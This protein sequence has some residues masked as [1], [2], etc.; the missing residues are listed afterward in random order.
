MARL[1]HFDLQASAQ[2][3]LEAVI[4]GQELG[5]SLQHLATAGCST[6][7]GFIRSADNE[8]YATPSLSLVE[9]HRQFRAGSVPSDWG[10][11]S[12]CASAGTSFCA[13]LSPSQMS[14]LRNAFYHDFMRPNGMAY[15]ARLG[16][17]SHDKYMRRF[18][19]FRS[20]HEAPFDAD[21]LHNLE[22]IIPH[23]NAAATICRTSLEKYVDTQSSLFSRRDLPAFKL[24][25]NGRVVEMNEPAGNVVPKILE[26]V[27]GRLTVPMASEQNHV[28]KAI[29]AAVA[30]AGTPSMVRLSGTAQY[31][32]PLFLTLP[33]S[34]PARDVFASAAAFAVVVDVAQKIMVNPRSLDLLSSSMQLTPR[35]SLV[36]GLV[37]SGQ[38]VAATALQL[39]IGVGT[40]RNHLKA[41]MQKGG[42]HSQVELA[43]LVAKLDGLLLP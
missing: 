7:S 40:V 6:G 3:L 38:S 24:A 15:R 9:L 2:G 39:D 23:L 41:A 10:K 16:L 29:K 31:P 28:D 5:E 21:E 22:A 14:G 26:V 36:V 32:N 18:N 30:G 19:F 17:P 37:A 42:V 8:F 27:R 43:A 35:E 11:V 4:L 33:I 12:N 25:A 1:N 34:G 13:D 20:D